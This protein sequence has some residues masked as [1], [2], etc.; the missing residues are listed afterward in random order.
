MLKLFL[1]SIVLTS[2]T[3]AIALAVP[4][5]HPA[6]DAIRCCDG[7]PGGTCVP[8]DHSVNKPGATSVGEKL[9]IVRREDGLTPRCKEDQP[10]TCA[11]EHG[12]ATT[13]H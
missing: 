1:L 3:A 10:P 8:C 6:T 13:Q 4:T 7:R 9:P 5:S 11:I 2:A 12:A